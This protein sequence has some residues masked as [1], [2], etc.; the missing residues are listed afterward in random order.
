MKRPRLIGSLRANRETALSL[1]ALLL[2]WCRQLNITTTTTT[3][4]DDWKVGATKRFPIGAF[5][6]NNNNNN[7]NNSNNKTTPTPRQQP[8]CSGRRDARGDAR[9]RRVLLFDKI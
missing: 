4:T 2:K 8:T 7:N 9:R 3:V 5:H 1:M 6:R